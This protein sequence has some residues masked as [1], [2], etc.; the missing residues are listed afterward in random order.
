[1]TF[2][3]DLKSHL[4]ADASIAALVADRIWP[5][6]RAQG[7]SLPAITYQRVAGTPQSDLDGDDGDLIEVRV[8]IDCWARGFEDVRTLAELVR[9]RL[10]T[11][12][13]TFRGRLLFDQD[14]YEDDVK[15]FRVSQD[16]ALWYRST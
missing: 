2:E 10:Q 9:V 8:Q 5:I 16:F 13:S 1:M 12:A 14:F 15:V 7:S 6:V 3:A 4:Q 11:A